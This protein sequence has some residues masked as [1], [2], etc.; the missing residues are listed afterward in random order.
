MRLSPILIW[1]LLTVSC[2]VTPPT[3]HSFDAPPE[4][5]AEVVRAVL[6]Q[7][8]QVEQAGG[9]FTTG[10]QSDESARR[11]WN[12]FGQSLFG[13]TRYRVRVVGSR[14]EVEASSRVFVSFGPHARRWE[15]VS[16]PAETGLIDRIGRSN[17]P[18]GHGRG[19]DG[20]S[21]GQAAAIIGESSSN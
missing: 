12:Q 9:T 2:Q 15:A 19:P 3:S 11:S 17:A 6:G 10:W 1:G 14:V 13:Q 18:R 16:F 4:K 7:G 20:G 5:V 8:G 21:F